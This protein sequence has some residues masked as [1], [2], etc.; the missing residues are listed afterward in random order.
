MNRFS[1][2][3]TGFAFVA[4][5][6]LCGCGKSSTDTAESVLLKC[7]DEEYAVLQFEEDVRISFEAIKQDMARRNR[8]AGEDQIGRI[9]EKCRLTCLQV[10]IQYMLARNTA[11]ERNF[12]VSSNAL[13]KVRIRYRKALGNHENLS[14]FESQIARIA[15]FEDFVQMHYGHLFGISEGD[16]EVAWS[17]VQC[18]ARMADATNAVLAATASNVVIRA[19][20]GEDFYRLAAQ[21]SQDAGTDEEGFAPQTRYSDFDA[22]RPGVKEAIM[23]LK[24]GEVTDPLD[25]DEGLSVYRLAEKTDQEEGEAELR[26]QRISFHRMLKYDYASKETLAVDL[27]KQ[28]AMAMRRTAIT[29]ML[30]ECEFEFPSGFGKFTKQEL[31]MLK[32][33]SR[34]VPSVAEAGECTGNPLGKAFGKQVEKRKEH[35]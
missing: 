27:K 33:F 8:L 4:I 2:C 6:A 14:D 19:R 12:V 32:P 34:G 3:G 13:E 21:Y 29:N 11:G 24:V 25:S 23:R 22:E 28:A 10:Q 16:V 9:E 1:F 15:Y 30:S 26:L 35:E 17:N 20:N 31:K 5:F 7:G 18:I